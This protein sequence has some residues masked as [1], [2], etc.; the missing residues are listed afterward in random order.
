MVVADRFRKN[1]RDDQN[2]PRKERRFQRELYILHE[3]R[4]VIERSK[5]MFIFTDGG[6]A[7]LQ[8]GQHCLDCIHHL[9]SAFVPGCLKI[10]AIRIASVPLGEF[11][12]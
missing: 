12:S 9:D 10:S 5:S 8:T 7:A 3:L 2:Q 6:S 11:A 1:R 4:I